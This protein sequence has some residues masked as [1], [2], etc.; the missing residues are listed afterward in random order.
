MRGETEKKGVGAFCTRLLE[1]RG[2]I[3]NKEHSEE[4]R[5]AIRVRAEWNRGWV[6]GRPPGH[7]TRGGPCGCQ[8]REGHWLR[9]REPGKGDPASPQKGLD[10][11]RLTSQNSYVL[12]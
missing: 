6:Q 8:E 10:S 5:E 7:M 3:H 9:Q 1:G 12:D 11:V 4:G 2:L